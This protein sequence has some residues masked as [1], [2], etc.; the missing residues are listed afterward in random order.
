MKNLEKIPVLSLSGGMDSSSLLLH[1]LR[2]FKESPIYSLSFNYGQKHHLELERLNK[3]LWFLREL[4]GEGEIPLS[5]L[6]IHH[7]VID[8][9]ALGHLFQSSLLTEGWSPP[10]GHYAEET[11]KETVVPNRNA[12]FSAILYGYALSIRQKTAR[13]VALCLGVHSGDHAIY[14]DCRPEFYEKLNEVFQ[15]GNWESESVEF[16]LPYLDGDKFTILQDAEKSC[17][18]LNVDF[19]R[20]FANTNTSYS[21]DSEG[22]ASGKTGSDVERILAFDKLGRIDPVEYQESWEIVVERAKA[23]ELA[24]EG[25]GDV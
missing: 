10:E 11:M 20:F 21:P 4:H 12:I 9:S 23:L 8:L 13:D 25:E 17:S 5:R 22:R 1:A 24:H 2:E 7:E 14:P 3:N 15:L 19:D 16:Y 6:E 18:E